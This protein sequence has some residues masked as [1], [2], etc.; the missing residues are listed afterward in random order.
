MDEDEITKVV[1][2]TYD[3]DEETDADL[4]I[5]KVSSVDLANKVIYA[6]RYH[7]CP[8]CTYDEKFS[9]SFFMTHN[10]NVLDP[11]PFEEAERRSKEEWEKEKREWEEKL[12]K[13]DEERKRHFE[14]LNSPYSKGQE[15][16]VLKGYPK[17]ALDMAV[18]TDRLFLDDC[19]LVDGEFLYSIKTVGTRKN[20]GNVIYTFR[21]DNVF[22]DCHFK[23]IEGSFFDDSLMMDKVRSGDF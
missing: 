4:K 6:Y 9:F 16:Q 10:V 7:E 18:K 11:V 19:A 13:E 12:R 8:C 1:F 2:F 3:E 22:K 23:I 21:T 17:K 15:V 20:R 14:E 5:Y